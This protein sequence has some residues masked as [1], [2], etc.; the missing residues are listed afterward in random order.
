[1]LWVIRG[2]FLAMSLAVEHTSLWKHWV[3]YP[4]GEEDMGPP[5]NG[6]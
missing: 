1:M 4:M 5:V 6:S 2:P 3:H